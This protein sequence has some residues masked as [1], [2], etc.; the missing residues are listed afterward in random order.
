[1]APERPNQFKMLLSDEEVQILRDLADK[2][3]L[4]ASD[5]LRQLLRR[6]Y[7]EIALAH[8]PQ[9][10]RPHVQPPRVVKRKPKK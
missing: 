8:L 4:T 5:Y 1:M 10:T 6:E 2:Q 3:G 9:L 7:A